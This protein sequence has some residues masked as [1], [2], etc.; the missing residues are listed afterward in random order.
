MKS[1]VSNIVTVLLFTIAIVGCGTKSGNSYILKGNIN[2]KYPITMN[3]TIADDDT[4]TGKYY[5]DEHKIDIVLTG[6]STKTGLILEEVVDGK[7]T[8]EFI[9]SFDK[10]SIVYR[11]NWVNTSTKKSMP[12]EVSVLG[13]KKKVVAKNSVSNKNESYLKRFEG[14]YGEDEG[15]T[16]RYITLTY[17]NP[18]KMLASVDGITYSGFEGGGNYILEYIDGQLV[19]EATTKIATIYGDENSTHNF[20]VYIVD[21]DTIGV[22]ESG[23]ST[24]YGARFGDFSGKHDKI[25]DKTLRS[26]NKNA[27]LTKFNGVYKTMGNNE[28]RVLITA[29]Y[30]GIGSNHYIGPDLMYFELKMF[31]SYFEKSF[32]ANYDPDYEVFIYSDSYSYSSEFSGEIQI[33]VLDE[34]RINV[35]TPDVYSINGEMYNSSEYNI[36]GIYK[37]K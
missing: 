25:S 29:S 19:F 20:T 6:D 7:M 31:D 4:V 32:V 2:E 33:T 1:F 12:F 5:Y 24:L 11:G 28:K 8:G 35:V 13:S 30:V 34:N 16:Y 10:D 26:G 27:T 23:S 21:D 14:T 18:T 17:I 22:D 3:I 37:K 9:G 36:N 15:E